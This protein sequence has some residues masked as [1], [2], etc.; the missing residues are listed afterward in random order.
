[1]S[2]KESNEEEESNSKAC[3]ACGKECE[4]SS[5]IELDGKRV[6]EVCKEKA[7]QEIKE[8]VDSSTAADTSSSKPR[9]SVAEAKSYWNGSLVIVAII[10]TIWAIISF[11]CSII[12]K[13]SL[14][15]IKIGSAGLGFWMSQQGSIIV[16]VL[17]LVLY[18]ILMNK[19][20]KK[21]GFDEED[22]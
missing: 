13:E 10:L 22:K 7:I 14:D 1:M 19:H 17:L 15:S 18:M 4:E 2:D 8:N 5:L 20:D 21:H 3:D 6:C 11:G 9:L 16:F 12:F